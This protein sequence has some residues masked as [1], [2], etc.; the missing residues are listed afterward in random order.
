LK[1]LLKEAILDEASANKEY[2]ATV[3]AYLNTA[4]VA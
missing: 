4:R 2:A 1:D 3:R